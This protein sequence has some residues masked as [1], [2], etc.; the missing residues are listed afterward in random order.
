MLADLGPIV[1]NVDVDV[2]VLVSKQ[3]IEN[4]K[5]IFEVAEWRWQIDITVGANMFHLL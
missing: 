3:K 5:C 2:Y 4:T 1:K